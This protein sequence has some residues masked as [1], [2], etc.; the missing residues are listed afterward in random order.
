M[1]FWDVIQ[2]AFNAAALP[3]PTAKR[4]AANDT[5]DHITAGW[6]VLSHDPTARRRAG[7]RG[8]GYLLR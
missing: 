7:A 5:E 2:H 6:P 3:P 1:P 8:D 4:Q